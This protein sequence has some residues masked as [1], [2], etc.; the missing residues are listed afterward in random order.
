L[1]PAYLAADVALGRRVQAARAWSVF[2]GDV[3]DAC[4]VM[5]YCEA[6]VFQ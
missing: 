2:T 1:H 6:R 4:R 3:T 5:G